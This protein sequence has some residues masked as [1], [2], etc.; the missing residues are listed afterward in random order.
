MQNPVNSTIAKVTPYHILYECAQ[1]EKSTMYEWV[2]L[3]LHL[4]WP[5]PPTGVM[6]PQVQGESM[7]T[8]EGSHDNEAFVQFRVPTG[9]PSCTVSL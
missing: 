2:N 7:C 8:A 1:S 4:Q 3:S 6:S 5:K 9:V